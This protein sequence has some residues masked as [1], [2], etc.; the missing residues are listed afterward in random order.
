MGYEIERKYLVKDKTIL[1]GKQ[2]ILYRQAYIET[3]NNNVVRLRTVDKKA[4]ITLKGQNEGLVRLEYE[5]EIPLE[6]ANEIIENLCQKPP[7]EKMRYII[8]YKGFEWVI[9][10]FMGQNHGLIMAEIELPN[11]DTEFSKPP[12]IGAEVTNDTRYYNSNLVKNPY[13]NWNN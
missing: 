11:K 7:I 5:Y 9:D 8:P 2:G 10:Q 4:Y 13:A 6:D 3:A 1:E 12:F